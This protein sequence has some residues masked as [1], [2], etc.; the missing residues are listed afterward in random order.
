M[1]FGAQKHEWTNT[2]VGSLHTYNDCCKEKTICFGYNQKTRENGVCKEKNGV[3][4]HAVG[5]Q[6]WRLKIE[7]QGFI[8]NCSILT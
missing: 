6:M 5:I 4:A 3:T 2:R 8:R 7:K 1:C